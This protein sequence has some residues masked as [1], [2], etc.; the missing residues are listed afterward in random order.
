[1]FF[2]KK[3]IFDETLQHHNDVINIVIDTKF[4]LL[5]HI[6]KT[7]GK[8][9]PAIENNRV[10]I[11]CAFNCARKQ[12][13]PEVFKKNTCQRGHML[14]RNSASSGFFFDI[15]ISF[16]K[17]KHFDKNALNASNALNALTVNDLNTNVSFRTSNIYAFGRMQVHLLANSLSVAACV[18]LNAEAFKKVNSHKMLK[19]LQ[20]E[21]IDGVTSLGDTIVEI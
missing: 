12:R 18:K 2:F 21:S 17:K 9:E 7:A 1:M 11:N 19:I 15:N 8:S 13:L 16:E 20:V 5:G 4:K 6:L 3:D 10:K 14:R